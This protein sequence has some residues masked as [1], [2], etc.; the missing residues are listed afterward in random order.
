[1]HRFLKIDLRKGYWQVPMHHG[2]MAKTTVITPF[3]LYKILVM[4]FSLCNIG[5]SSQCMMDRVICSLSFVFCCLDHLRVAS[6][7]PE[8]HINNL[9]VLFQCFRDFGLVI[10][11]KKCTFHVPEIKFLSSLPL[12]SKMDAV[13]HF[14]PPVKVKT[15]RFS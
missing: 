7:S 10:N 12:S 13:Q 3:G 5:S 2:D 6:P 15:Y 9:C 8:E 14:P 11:L 4:T 1:M